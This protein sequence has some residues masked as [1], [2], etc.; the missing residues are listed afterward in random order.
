MSYSYPVSEAND[1]FTSEAKKKKLSFPC[2]ENRTFSQNSK[3]AAVCAEF[4]CKFPAH[5]NACSSLALR[6]SSPET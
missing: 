1:V 2:K 4:R 3:A 6:V 5:Y